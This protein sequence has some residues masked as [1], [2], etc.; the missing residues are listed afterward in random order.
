M[1]AQS[2]MKEM[3]YNRDEEESK[4]WGGVQIDVFEIKII[5]YNYFLLDN[6]M[7][8]RYSK[9]LFYRI[10]ALKAERHVE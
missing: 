4:W 1:N 5:Q 6:N 2:K 7:L 8:D 3:E 10:I 9:L